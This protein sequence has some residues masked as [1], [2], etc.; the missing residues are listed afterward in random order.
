ME[1]ARVLACTICGERRT[2]R[3]QWFLISEDR[4][5][6]KLKI[7]HWDDRL[8]VRPGIH[9]ACSPAHLQ[10][11]VVHWMTAGSLNHPF[12]RLASGAAIFQRP[13]RPKTRDEAAANRARQIGEISVHRE[14]MQ[15]VLSE[16]PQSLRTILDA[17]LSALHRDTPLPEPALKWEAAVGAAPHEM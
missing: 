10:E 12:A 2:G 5:G 17:L 4:W 7:L 6:D 16:S 11:L 3:W 15:R 8:A 14:S 13:Y 1:R 9:C